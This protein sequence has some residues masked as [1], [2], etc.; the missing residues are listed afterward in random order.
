MLTIVAAMLAWALVLPGVQAAKNTSAS[1]DYFVYI[2]TSTGKNSKGIYTYGFHSSDGKLT[3]IGLV[4]E[5]TNPTFLAGTI[6]V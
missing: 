1:G 4:A 5:I 6:G 2:G 3:P